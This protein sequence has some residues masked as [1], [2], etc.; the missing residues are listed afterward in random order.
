MVA[1]LALEL[2]EERGVAVAP[3]KRLLLW[4]V[5]ASQAVRRRALGSKS[6]VAHKHTNVRAKGENKQ[7][8]AAVAVRKPQNIL[9]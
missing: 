6:A 4:V 9:I 2:L 5:A 7:P 1:V 3:R 8:S